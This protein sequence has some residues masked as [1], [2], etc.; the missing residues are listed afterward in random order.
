[1]RYTRL[2]KIFIFLGLIFTLIA[3][4][5][6]LTKS[7]VYRLE[8]SGYET[9]AVNFEDVK[10]IEPDF[11]V[12]GAEEVYEIYDQ[13]DRLTAYL[14]VFEDTEELE[15]MFEELN[16]NMESYEEQIHYNLLIVPY[17]KVEYIGQILIILKR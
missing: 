11:E 12:V 13:M 3:C 9:I 1:M 17:E 15:Q 10:R 16:L 7:V 5:N 6:S 14:Y 8:D 4:N 2:L